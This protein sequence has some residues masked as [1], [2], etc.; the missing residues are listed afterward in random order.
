VDYLMTSYQPDFA[1]L[2]G[3]QLLGVV[4]RDRALQGLVQETEDSYVTG[5]MQRDV[6]RLSGTMTLAEAQEALAESYTQVAA[7]FDGDRYLGLVNQDDIREALQI[8]A[9]LRL[10]WEKRTLLER[11]EAA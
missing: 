1:V 6:L 8:S 9:F 2:H 10:A 5:I 11:R 3:G 7:V 4:T